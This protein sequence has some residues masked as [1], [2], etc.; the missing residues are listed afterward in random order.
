[1]DAPRT[2]GKLTGPQHELR[3][4]ENT[5]SLFSFV[6]LISFSTDLQQCSSCVVELSGE[7]FRAFGLALVLGPG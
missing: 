5:I 6:D 7:K 3:Y 4:G 1:M 2:G